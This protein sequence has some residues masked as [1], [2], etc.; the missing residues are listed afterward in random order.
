MG[1]HPWLRPISSLWTTLCSL[2][3][4]LGLTLSPGLGSRVEVWT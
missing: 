1:W 2:E 4:G 3:E